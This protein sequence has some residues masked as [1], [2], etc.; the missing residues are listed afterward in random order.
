LRDRRPVSRQP[1]GDVGDDVGARGSDRGGGADAPLAQ[2]IHFGRRLFSRASRSSPSRKSG[3]AVETSALARSATDLPF[4]FTM[5]CS[6]TTYLT[7]V[8]G[9]VTMFPWV[10]VATIR[11]LRSPPRSNVEA[12]HMNDLPP[13]DA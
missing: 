12:R 8:R 13:R 2:K 3:W 10:R 4:R 5:P 9:V 7:S 6:V 11:L 1:D